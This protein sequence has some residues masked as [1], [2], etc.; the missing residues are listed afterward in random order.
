MERGQ[1]QH[2]QRQGQRSRPVLAPYRL[3]EDL[4]DRSAQ[5]PEA[6]ERRP[7]WRTGLA[8]FAGLAAA[9]AIGAAFQTRQVRD[10]ELSAAAKAERFAAFRTQQPFR[11]TRL[12]DKAR[13]AA[14]AEM[15]LL[16]S[17]RQALEKDLDEGRAYLSVLVLWDDQVQDGDAVSVSGGGFTRSISLTKQPQEITV[18]VSAAGTPYLV[19]GTHDGGAGITVA[20]TSGGSTVPLPIMSPGETYDLVLAGAP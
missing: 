15:G 7:V 3:P 20:A 2:D 8:A 5:V 4:G 18:P 1:R 19:R 6:D 10:Q 11:L 16:P 17:A 14:I 12:P 13:N 9:A